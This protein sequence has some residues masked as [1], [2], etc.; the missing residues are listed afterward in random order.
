MRNRIL[1]LAIVGCLLWSGPAAADGDVIIDLQGVVYYDGDDYAVVDA[2]GESNAPLEGSVSFADGLWI[3][4][5]TTVMLPVTTTL[6]GNTTWS[7]RLQ[8]TPAY[9]STADWPDDAV[10][11]DARGQSDNY[12]VYLEFEDYDD[13]YHVFINGADRIQSNPRTWAA[14]TPLDLWLTLDFDG[15]ARIIENGEVI[16][17]YNIA[18]LSPPANVYTITLGSDVYGNQHANALYTEFALLDHALTAVETAGYSGDF[19]IAMPPAGSV[20]LQEGLYSYWDMDE[21]G[22]VR[23]DSQDGQHLTDNNTV[24][25][26]TG[27]IGS[28]ALFVSANSE[29]LSYESPHTPEIWTWAG[30]A[31]TQITTTGIFFSIPPAGVGL[32]YAPDTGVYLE[33]GDYHY[34]LP[35][36]ITSTWTHMALWYDGAAYG[37]R[38]NQRGYTIP[39]PGP[40]S[41]IQTAI[42]M[43]T[44]LNGALDEWGIWERLLSLDELD[45]LAEPTE[46]SEFE[47][48]ETYPWD[49]GEIYLPFVGHDYEYVPDFVY[50]TPTPESPY[51][52]IDY[53]GDTSWSDWAE[54]IEGWF[55]PMF[56]DISAAMDGLT[57]LRGAVCGAGFDTTAGFLPGNN[58]DDPVELELGEDPTILE[59]SY[60]L[61]IAMG[62]PFGYIRAFYS[63]LPL[64]TQSNNVG[65]MNFFVILMYFIPAALVWIVDV[66]IFVYYM[67]FVTFVINGGITAYKMIP[68]KAT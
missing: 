29:S 55:A 56:L 51:I 18:A 10:L 58:P 33:A 53:S 60:S 7:A 52:S 35:G 25:T 24:M 11:F 40:T 57:E 48:E 37:A 38:L 9:S 43:G 67:R 41:G 4:D 47:T 34:L 20:Q 5:T 14:D 21:N 42:Y 54:T 64:I 62:R 8:W 22:G 63:W 16:A 19:V 49:G 39:D 28:A 12:R 23:Y 26:T 15:A 46:Y 27:M 65:G 68:F 6:A 13:R 36:V 61:G 66:V 50:P 31:K 2:G 3:T 59:I 44:S 17:S 32:R 45:M 1:L 30:W